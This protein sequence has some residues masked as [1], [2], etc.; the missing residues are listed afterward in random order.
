MYLK[1]LIPKF[2]KMFLLNLENTF[3]GYKYIFTTIQLVFF[4]I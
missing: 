2:T 1:F 3:L 4:E